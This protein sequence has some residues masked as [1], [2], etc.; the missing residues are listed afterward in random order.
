MYFVLLNSNFGWLA[1]YG[2]WRRDARGLHANSARQATN[3][4]QYTCRKAVANAVRTGGD[5]VICERFIEKV[6]GEQ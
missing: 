1:S 4:V 6:T 2:L 3:A 5:R